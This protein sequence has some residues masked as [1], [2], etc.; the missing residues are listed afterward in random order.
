MRKV[1]ILTDNKGWHYNQLVNS[2]NQKNVIVESCNLTDM[3]ISVIKENVQILLNNKVITD[4]TDVFV[5][6]IPTGT[7][8]EVVTNLNILK[9]LQS[10]GLNVMNT[11]EN[12]ELTVDKSLTSMKL[13]DNG[14]L[15]PNTWITR[16][17]NNTIKLSKIYHCNN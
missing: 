5:R 15:T 8:E 11:A 9:A 1:L 13:K 16:G 17:K 4:I 12:I 14:I 3:S 2:F 10:K 6:H 7:L